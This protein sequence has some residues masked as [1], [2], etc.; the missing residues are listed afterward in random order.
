MKV[1]LVYDWVDTLGGAER[2]LVQLKKIFPQ[3]PLFTSVYNKSKA[4]WAKNFKV[5]NSFLQNF[6]FSQNYHQIYPFLTPISFEQFDFSGFDIVISVTSADSK[7]IITKP[8]TLHICYLLTP[9]RYIWSHYDVYIQNKLIKFLSKPVISYLRRWDLVAKDRPDVIIS[10]SQTVQKRVKQ[11]YKR[12]SNIIYPPVGISKPLKSAKISDYFL[13]V[14]RLVPYKRIDLTI[15][16]CNKLKKNLV[17]IGDGRVY[18]SLRS[19]AGSTVIFKENVSESELSSYYKNCKALIIA[20]EEDFGLTAVECQMHGKPVIALGQGGVLETVKKGKTGIFFKNQS[21]EDI[22]ASIESFE[23][24]HFSSQDCIE[25]VRTFS[26]NSF[27]KEFT[28]MVNF[29]YKRFFRII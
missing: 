21:V 6:P 20:C 17:I 14:S 11:Y 23:K 9:T 28:A 2:V 15:K 26:E 5:V 19:I 12:D 18:G 8:N 29:H 4:D 13:V 25:N 7:A 3:A 22:I 27:K 10:I 16:A 24:L 1:A